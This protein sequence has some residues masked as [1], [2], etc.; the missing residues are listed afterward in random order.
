MVFQQKNIIY[1]KHEFFLNGIKL[2]KVLKYKYLGNI[3]E[4]SGKLNSSFTELSKK[5]AKILFSIFKYLSPLERVSIK[6]YKK[7]FESLVK[8]VLMYNS[9]IW[10]M[11]FH[12]KISNVFNRAQNNDLNNFDMLSF[13]DK[14]PTNLRFCKYVLGL[15][16]RSVNIAARAKLAQYP[17]D[18]FIKVQSLK[19]LARISSDG[20][21]SLIINGCLFSLKIT[22]FSWYL[23]MVFLCR[24]HMQ[25]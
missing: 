19:Y 9:E 15:S 5:G 23:L 7:L 20:N 12:E 18:V 10:Y 6:I 13:I 22:A 2:E 1:N 8:P 14:S 21:N 4:A 24:K 25:I 17:V 16:K 3:I 11:D